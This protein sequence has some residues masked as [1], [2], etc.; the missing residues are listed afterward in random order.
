MLAISTLGLV[1]IEHDGEPVTGLETR[2]A[3]ALLLYLA[4]TGRVHS[5]EVLAEMFWP[6]RTS[7][8]SLGNLR[9]ALSNL[10]KQVGEY[11]LIDRD[12]LSL[13]P[14][15]GVWLDVAELETALTADQIERA[16]D[17]YRG[18]FFEG[19]YLPDSPAFEDWSTL[20]RERLRRLVHNAMRDQVAHDLETGDYRE[21]IR[22]AARLL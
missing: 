12:T 1:T 3:E 17:L 6:E 9:V 19:F 20:E 11:L 4:C 2:K 10:R 13:D 5:R 18:D 7:E 22:H 15:A 16:L 8:R 14:E 21:G